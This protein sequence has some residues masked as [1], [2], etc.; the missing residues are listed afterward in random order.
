[1]ILASFSELFALLAILQIFL[2]LIAGW[3]IV[4]KPKQSNRVMQALAY[5]IRGHIAGLIGALRYMFG[6]ERGCW[7]RVN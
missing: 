7:K 4:F 3:Q 6:L 2:Y 5:L 1:M